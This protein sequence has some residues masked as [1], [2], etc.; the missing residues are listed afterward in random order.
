MN[1]METR[2]DLVRRI[3]D[4][5]VIDQL[6]IPIVFF[7]LYCAVSLI[8]F[9]RYLDGWDL[10]IF[11]QAVKA[12]SR[13]EIPLIPLKAQEPFNILGDHF[14]PVI[15]LIGP[16]YR[17]FPHVQ[18]LLIVQAALF[19]VSV[20][21]MGRVAHKILPPMYAAP[22]AAC[23]GM[24]WTVLAAVVFDFH[25]VCFVVPSL[26]LAIGAAWEE[27]WGW[28]ALWCALLALTKED[29]AFLVG[30]IALMLLARRRVRAG[31]ILGAS[32]VAYFV[33]VVE[34]VIPHFSSS[35]TYAY[36]SATPG[37]ATDLMGNMWAMVQHP[38]MWIICALAVLT[39]GPGI[40]TAAALVPVPVLLS[41]VVVNNPIYWSYSLHYQ[42]PVFTACFFALILGWGDLMASC[43]PDESQDLRRVRLIHVHPGAVVRRLCLAYIAA[44]FIS[45]VAIAQGEWGWQN[46]L[47]VEPAPPKVASFDTVIAEVPPDVTIVADTYAIGHLV[48]TDT[49]YLATESWTDSEGEP[50]DAD[51]VLLDRETLSQN[52]PSTSW[53]DRRVN[54]L[55]TAGFTVVTQDGSVVLLTKP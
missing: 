52:N 8:R 16:I 26:I 45:S 4:R 13:W 48:D 34:V 27:R 3:R 5:P 18:T 50:L 1:A 55:L 32:S 46:L 23:F 36:F 54:T 25:E 44:L 19:A 38:R 9:S 6:V 37:S 49:V 47:G 30:G 14:S 43:H 29:S 51:W 20:A 35:G 41:R 22:V 10:G 11:A 7:C 42:A 40:R 33:C 28:M 53:V 12:Y 31:L 39:C 2:G 17:V 21:L 15:A 24:S